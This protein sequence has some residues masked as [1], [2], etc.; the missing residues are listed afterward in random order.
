[1]GGWHERTIRY[2]KGIHSRQSTISEWVAGQWKLLGY[3]KVNDNANGDVWVQSPAFN[4]SGL[5]NPVLSM[6]VKY[7]LTGNNNRV[8]VQYSTDGGNTWLTLG[9][10]SDPLWYNSTN[11]G[12]WNN[13]YSTPVNT[14]TTV[15]HSICGALGQTCVIFRISTNSLYYNGSNAYFAF[16][17]FK[18]SDMP[19]VGVLAYTAPVNTGCNFSNNQQVTVSVFNFGCSQA[20]NIPITCQISGQVTTTLSGT[21]TTAI[22]AGTSSNYTFTTPFDMSAIGTYKFTTFTSLSGDVNHLNDTA[23][24]TIKVTQPTISALP[25]TETFNANNGYWTA[26]GNSTDTSRHFT[27]GSLP[28]L[29]GAQGDG[30]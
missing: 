20:N 11:Y 9:S 12:S 27:W 26:G 24:T 28:Y 13:N 29:N 22:P 16:D 19:D 21:I 2:I 14:W 17:N 6:N 1:M 30:R 18:I 10:A 7:Q 5:S 4:L 23:K 8:I 3:L 25:Y 15:E